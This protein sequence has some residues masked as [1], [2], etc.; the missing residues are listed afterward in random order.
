MW[1]KD[2][3]FQKHLL[4]Q[5]AY[6]WAPSNSP[7]LALK[8]DWAHPVCQKILFHQ[9]V[10]WLQAPLDKG[11]NNGE[12]PTTG[13]RVVILPLC[14]LR[15][16]CLSLFWG[17]VHLSSLKSQ[18]ALLIIAPIASNWFCE[19]C[20]PRWV[21]C[22]AKWGTDTPY[23]IRTTFLALPQDASLSSPLVW[24]AGI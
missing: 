21:L 12:F 6:S 14:R 1:S 18:L 19:E 10:L 3:L 8:L 23:S 15:A 2:F 16:T 7:P 24:D 5:Y 11:S 22:F 17:W 13:I 20:S 9:S 4:V